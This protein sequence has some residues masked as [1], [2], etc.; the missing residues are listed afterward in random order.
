MCSSKDCRHRGGNTKQIKSRRICLHIHV[1][2]CVLR[3][4]VKPVVECSEEV[5]SSQDKVTPISRAKTVDLW[6]SYSLPYPIPSEYVAQCRNIDA[7]TTAGVDDKSWPS[8]FEPL[9]S[10]CELC[11]NQLDLP[12]IKPGSDGQALLMTSQH[13]FRVIT[14]LV[15]FCGNSECKAMHRVWPLSDGKTWEYL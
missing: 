4:T 11:G 3:E 5:V 1:L 14:I 13:P 9:Q 7:W 6:S 15:K 8:T 12:R 10:T 2:L